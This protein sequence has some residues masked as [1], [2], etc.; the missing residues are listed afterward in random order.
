M[1]ITVT[2]SCAGLHDGQSFAFAPGE[3]VEVP[4]ALGEDLVR[5]GYAEKRVAPKA[6]KR[7][8]APKETRG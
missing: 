8:R 3:Q 2:E 7:V 4:T 5:A 6:E 1:K